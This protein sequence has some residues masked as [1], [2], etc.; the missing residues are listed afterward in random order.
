MCVEPSCLA[1][2]DPR[3]QEAD[4]VVLE[5][6]MVVLGRRRQ[7]VE[8]IGPR[9]G[10]CIR[11]R[12]HEATYSAPVVHASCRAASPVPGSRLPTTADYTP[13]VVNVRRIGYLGVR[14]PEV[15]GMT[16]FLR[17]VLGLPG[18]DTDASRT[19]SGL[20]SG[21]FDLA[22]VYS[23]DH[24]DERMI[25]HEV[26]GI[27]VSFIVDDLEGALEEVKEAGLE[28]VGDV[29]WAAEAFEAPAMKGVGWFWLR[30]PDGRI[31]AVEQSVD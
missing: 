14:T 7:R 20:P 8:R 22:E 25:P 30:A 26:D 21:R 19:A 16:W 6:E 24:R 12:H 18:G 29:I 11:L 23:P 27:I 3:L 4:G 10:R 1:R 28:L 17:D 9:P 2:S 15:E 5:E 31:Y 13:P